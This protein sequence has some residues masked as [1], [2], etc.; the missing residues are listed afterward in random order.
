MLLTLAALFIS[1]LVAADPSASPAGAHGAVNGKVTLTDASGR[2][3]G[4]VGASAAVSSVRTASTAPADSRRASAGNNP[5]RQRQGL[6][7]SGR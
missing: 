7:N 6:L 3:A 1:T 4:D 2:A 5:L